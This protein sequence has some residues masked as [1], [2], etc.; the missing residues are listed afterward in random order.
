MGPNRSALLL[1]AV[2]TLAVSADAAPRRRPAP[3]QIEVVSAGADQALRLGDQ[4]LSRPFGA[5]LVDRVVV[6]SRHALPGSRTAWL[7]RGEGGADC[8][9][10]YVVVS[11][12]AA[13]APSV[14]APFGT[15]SPGATART[16]RGDLLVTMPDA[17]GPP[18]SFA[19]AGGAMRPI[20]SAAML[21]AAAP[22]ACSAD[23]Q[24]SPELLDA[25]LAETLPLDLRRRGGIRRAELDGEVL[26]GTV[27]D[28]ACLA[29]W[30]GG[31]PKVRKAA[32]PLFASKRYGA[33]AFA[34]LDNVARTPGTDTALRAAVRT[35]SAQMYYAV[36]SR[37]PI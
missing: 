37:E 31:D 10:R 22:T 12:R 16:A 20:G 13:E 3:A 2:A 24:R 34:A 7:V 17:A 5:Q 15:C 18:V 8:P 30:P 1:A 35:F 4:T 32:T 26:E 9:A 19:W 27:A 14:T 25:A 28:L 21:L 6:V 33:A 36:G 29:A 11:R 23:A